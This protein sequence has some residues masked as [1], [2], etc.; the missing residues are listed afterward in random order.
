MEFR[1]TSL[2]VEEA[3]QQLGVGMRTIIN[4]L[5]CGKLEGNKVGKRW[6]INE[7]SFK[8]LIGEG[9]EITESA[10]E[11]VEATTYTRNIA[12][13]KKDQEVSSSPL[14]SASWNAPN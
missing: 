9:E 2:S 10:E 13:M 14:S 11:K 5:H 7:E 6:F 3:A 1:K 8:N 12:I 4:Y